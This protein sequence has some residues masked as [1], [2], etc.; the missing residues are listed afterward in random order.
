[1]PSPVVFATPDMIGEL[2]SC[3]VRLM[4]LVDWQH[5]FQHLGFLLYMQSQSKVHDSQHSR[6]TNATAIIIV[7]LAS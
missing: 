4:V 2:L 3:E 5:D 7:G 6:A 1:M